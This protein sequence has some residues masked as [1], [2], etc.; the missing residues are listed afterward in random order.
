MVDS[1][2][3]MVDWAWDTLFCEVSLSVPVMFVGSV[4]YG[5]MGFL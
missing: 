3:G 1:R 4:R 5:G 2:V